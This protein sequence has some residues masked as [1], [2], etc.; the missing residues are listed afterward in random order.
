MTT[1]HPRNRSALRNRRH[2]APV[3]GLLALALVAAMP[4]CAATPINETRPL[5]PMGS[6][7]ID[8]VKGLIQV[9]AWDR[10]EVRIEGSLGEGVEKLEIE[11]DR[12][13]LSIK[14]RYP[15]RGSGMGFL[16]GGDKSEPTELRLTV[17]LQAKLEIDAVSATVDVNGVAPRDLSIDSV[18]GDVI[19]AAAPREA[20]I[21]SVSGD[22]RLTLNSAKVSAQTVSG[23]LSLRG[24]LNGEVDIETVSGKVDVTTRESRLAKLSGN[25]VSGDLRVT[26]ALADGGEIS[27]E[28][29]SGDVRLSLP[30]V[31]S[32]TVRGQSFS[33]DLSA[34]EAQIVRPKHGP[35]SSFE[36]RYGNGSGSIKIET[37][38]GDATLELN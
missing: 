9:R 14:V 21:E 13:H 28:T 32:A 17:P 29:V 38:S 26:G 19:V 16:V 25:S 30:R 33:G 8:N 31:L 22:L 5:D 1:A 24:R 23:D 20:E 35:G 4:A 34:P 36:H 15:N 6:I 18:S 11:G 3:L 12:E 2:I 10:P 27:L 37:F 7:D